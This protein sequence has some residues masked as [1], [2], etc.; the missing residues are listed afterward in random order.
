M[1]LLSE[2]CYFPIYFVLD[3]KEDSP[4]FLLQWLNISKKYARA[5]AFRMCL[6]LVNNFEVFL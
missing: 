1:S 3:T 4:P 5:L 6:I 2:T